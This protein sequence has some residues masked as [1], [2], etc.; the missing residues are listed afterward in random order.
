MKDVPAPSASVVALN[1]MFIMLI[2][3]MLSSNF[4]FL[5]GIKTSA[6]LPEL[7]GAEIIQANKL[8]V[9]ISFEIDKETQKIVPGKY[10]YTFN[11]MDAVHSLDEV[12]KEINETLE[13]ANRETLNRTVEKNSDNAKAGKSDETSPI[14][15]LHADKEIPLQ[16]LVN[17]YS[18]LRE[19][20]ATIV[21]A[22][23][24]EKKESNTRIQQAREP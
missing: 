8:I 2:F 22:T 16:E 12:M 18:K 4:I 21:L 23:D 10:I 1:L 11:G 15:I 9:T 6:T 5:P 24:F 3:F 20:N 17:C 7:P 13:N 14:I 19:C